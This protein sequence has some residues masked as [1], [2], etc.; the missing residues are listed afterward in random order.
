MTRM[1]KT[2]CIFACIL[3]TVMSALS[4]Q[5]MCHATEAKRFEFNITEF[6]AIGDGKTINT[7]AIQQAVDECAKNGGGTIVIP[8]GTF[9]C[10][11][12]FLKNNTELRLAPGAIL[13]ASPNRDDYCKLDAYPQNFEVLNEGWGAAHLI[14]G[15]NVKN[16]SITGEGTIDGSA[17]VFLGDPRPAP[18]GAT[19]W[20]HG[21]AWT[22]GLAHNTAPETARKLARPGQLIVFCESQSVRM[23]NISVRNAPSWCCFIYG[24][25]DVFVTGIKIDNPPTFANSDGLDIDSCRNVVVSDCRIITGDDAIAVR[26]APSHLLNKERACEHVVITNCVLSSSSSVFRIGV[27]NG[28]IRDVNIS[29]I[30]ILTGAVGFHF[31]SSYN[32]SAPRGVNISR[33]RCSNV[34][35]RAVAYPIKITP[36]T[37]TATATIED[38]TFDGIYAESYVGLV[39]TG[40]GKTAPKRVTVR[41]SEFVAVA[42]PIEMSRFPEAYFSVTD[43]ASARFENVTLRWDNAKHWQTPS[44]FTKAASVKTIN[45]DWPNPPAETKPAETK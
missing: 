24:C 33:V 30:I 31:Q 11:T 25:E 29:N 45:C 4:W 27:G 15:V 41:N 6:G 39:V 21:F 20:R 34:N 13:K 43:G 10:G 40:N 37:K 18:K 26:G 22:K 7:K 19:T 38:I 17:D 42:S 35:M 1:K 36:G 12:I 9:V 14:V 5:S 44:D 28:T 3:C 23:R 2:V 32:A 8:P 16:V